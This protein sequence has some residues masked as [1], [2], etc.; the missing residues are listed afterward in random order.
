MKTRHLPTM[1]FFV[2]IAL[3]TRAALLTATQAES[4]LT[5]PLTKP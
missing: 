3:E 2:A 4:C 1:V 5:F